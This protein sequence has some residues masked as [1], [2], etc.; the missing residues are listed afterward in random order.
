[1]ANKIQ[2]KTEKKNKQ[3][4]NSRTLEYGLPCHIR[5]YVNYHTKK[6]KKYKKIVS[7]RKNDFQELPSVCQVG[8]S[9]RVLEN[10]RVSKSVYQWAKAKVVD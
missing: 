6:K 8:V 3:K 2:K 7:P 9:S 5:L 10:I 4:Y 1:L